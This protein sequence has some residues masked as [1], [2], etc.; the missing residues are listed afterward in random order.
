MRRPASTRSAVMGSS[1]RRSPTAFATAL[2]IADD[3]GS[4]DISPT[5]SAPNEP[6][7]VVFDQ[8]DAELRNVRGAGDFVLSEIDCLQLALFD[9]EFLG[10]RLPQTL[11]QPPVDL[12]NQSHRIDRAA[13]V[14]DCYH[15]FESHLTGVPIDVEVDGMAG[16]AGCA[17]RGTI[18]NLLANDAA[19]AARQA[20]GQIPGELRALPLTRTNA[21]PSI[22][23]V[24]SCQPS[25]SAASAHRRSRTRSAA[26]SAAPP[27][28]LVTLLPPTP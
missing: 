10:E 4:A 1:V 27:V 25:S 24:S 16:K 19:F 17:A 20:P 14:V 26:R 7:V 9:A 28:A 3:A 21:P 12:T 22:C 11:H 15:F 18:V 6:F 13:D 8:L 2:A 5:P 23:T